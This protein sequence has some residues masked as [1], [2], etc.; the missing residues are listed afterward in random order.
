[1]NDDSRSV[2]ASLLGE[3]SGR[4]N[5]ERFEETEYFCNEFLKPTLNLPLI[6]FFVNEISSR[7]SDNSSFLFLLNFS[8]SPCGDPILVSLN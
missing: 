6:F 3:R 5:P 1:M 2:P 7:L 8:K 4:F